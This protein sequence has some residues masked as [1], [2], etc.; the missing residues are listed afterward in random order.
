MS[1]GDELGAF[2]TVQDFQLTAFQCKETRKAERLQ[3]N[4]WTVGAEACKYLNI[5]GNGLL[6]QK[7]TL[8]QMPFSEG[9]IEHDVWDLPLQN[10]LN[11]LAALFLVLC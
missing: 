6:C 8:T 1:H 10:A 9:V 11:S 2:N 5:E 7:I 4:I 3:T